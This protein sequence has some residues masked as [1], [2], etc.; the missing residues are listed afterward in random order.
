MPH[1]LF[2]CK[3]CNL[4][5]NVLFL[6]STKIELFM[7]NIGVVSGMMEI[8]GQQIKIK[9]DVI[10]FLDNGVVVFYC[11]AVDVY[12][13]GNNEKEA[14]ESLYVCMEEFFTYALENNTLHSELTRL[15]W[16][17]DKKQQ[18]VIPPV[19]SSL[20]R[21]NK[22]L[23]RIMDTRKFAKSNRTFIIPAIA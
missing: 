11:P 15:G 3:V 2:F 8:K 9:L 14:R 19:F 21:K 22:T 6:Y 4:T 18:Q 16:R 7:P 12:G 10:R 1:S 23:N 17:L 13:Y 5:K 20:L